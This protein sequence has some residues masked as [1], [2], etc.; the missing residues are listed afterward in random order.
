MQ[1]MY[2]VMFEKKR[3]FIETLIYPAF[4]G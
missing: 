3:N 1:I 4:S 2:L